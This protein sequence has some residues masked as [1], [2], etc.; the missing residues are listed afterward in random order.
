MSISELL[1]KARKLS[2]ELSIQVSQVEKGLVDAHNVYVGFQELTR[3][4]NILENCLMKEKFPS[5]KQRELWRQK[6][7]ELS[8]ESKFLKSSLDK[9]LHHATAEDREAKEREELLARRQ[10]SMPSVVIDAYMEEGVSIQHSSQIVDD[11]LT[12]GSATLQQLVDQR[13]NFKSIQKRAL[14]TMTTLG[15]TSGLMRGATRREQE[16]R[17]ILIVGCLITLLVLWVTVK[18]IRG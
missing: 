3:Q 15:L 9:F 14:D 12:S 1:P 10:A 6:V 2:Y 17:I 8:N 5:R 18:Y 7:D 11:I 13:E 16:D 4:L